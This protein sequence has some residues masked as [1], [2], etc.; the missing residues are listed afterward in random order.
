MQPFTTQSSPK[1]TI[2]TVLITFVIAFA[3][4][5]LGLTVTVA[6]WLFLEG[7]LA[8][9]MA[10]CLFLVSRTYWTIQIRDDQIALYNHANRQTYLFEDLKQSDLRITQTEKQKENN[11]CDMRIQD[12]PFRIYD[13]ASYS[14]M[15]AY[16]REHMP[17]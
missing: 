7:I 10:Y 11:T 8:L 3:L 17:E 1:K 16:I 9:T 12:A 13:A 6:L 2:R 4:A 15:M 14:E 5:F